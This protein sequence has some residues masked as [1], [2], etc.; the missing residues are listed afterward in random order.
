[1]ALA[2]GGD[3]DRYFP[4]VMMMLSSAGQVNIQNPT[5]EQIEYLTKLRHAILEAYTAVLHGLAMGNKSKLTSLYCVAPQ[6]CSG[7]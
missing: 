7:C 2:V 4:F 3:F 5:E 1:M 6:P